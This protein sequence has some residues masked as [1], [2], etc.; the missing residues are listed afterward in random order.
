MVQLINPTL[1]FRQN[2]VPKRVGLLILAT[3]HTL[4]LE[5]SRLVAQ[6]DLGIYTN[7][8]KF[9][10][11]TTPENLR[12]MLPHISTSAQMLL[13]ETD[14]DVIFY[15]CTS[16]SVVIGDDVIIDAVHSAKPSAKVITP[17]ISALKAFE[18]LGVKKIALLTPYLAQTSAPLQPYFENH[19]L[20]IVNHCC[21]GME[22][23]R[24]MARL[25]GQCVINAAIKADHKDAQCLFI[26]CTALRS[27]EV[28]GEIEMQ[29]GKPVVTSNQAAVWQTLGLLGLKGPNKFACKLFS[30]PYV[31]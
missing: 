8:V 6:D 11:P 5:F 25:D 3:D 19:G 14:F 28:A 12:A 21:L 31:L 18:S 24:D 16:A 17:T 23:D 9:A 1:T 10:N 20:E 4:E 15:G 2:I 27:L 29:I 22:D 7:R 30:T 26:S 13:P